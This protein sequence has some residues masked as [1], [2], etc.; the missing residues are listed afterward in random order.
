MLVLVSAW[1]AQ[2]I[3]GPAEVWMTWWLLSETVWMTWTLLS[4]NCEVTCEPNVWTER[5]DLKGEIFYFNLVA[6]V[7][8]KNITELG[9][10][11]YILYSV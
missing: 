4:Y 1:L 9:R 3:T 5:T 8:A 10:I 6:L 11:I 7:K 2:V